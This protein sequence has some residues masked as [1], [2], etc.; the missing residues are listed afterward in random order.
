MSWYIDTLLEQ[1][2]D[3]QKKSCMPNEIRKYLITH[4]PQI[5]L[6]SSSLKTEEPRS[7]QLEKHI[8]LKNEHIQ[9]NH[10]N[11]WH[12][13]IID[14]DVN[15]PDAYLD[16]PVPVPN[17]IVFNPDS[18]HCQRW[19][20]LKNGV[21]RTYWAKRSIQDYYLNTLFKLTALYN[22]DAF[23]N[24]MLARN[25]FHHKHI[26]LYPRLETYTLKE[27]NNDM[28]ISQ[29]DYEKGNLY[30]SDAYLLIQ[31]Y[32]RKNRKLSENMGLG[33]NCT[34]FD[35]LRFKAY[36]IQYEYGTEADFAIDLKFEA[37]KINQDYFSQDQLSD[38]ELKHIANSIARYC[39]KRGHSSQSGK[40]FSERQKV[41]GTKGGESRSGNYAIA[42]KKC[43]DLYTQEPSLKVS[44]IA[45]EC[46]VSERTIRNY[47]KEIKKKKEPLVDFIY[48]STET[49]KELA[50]KFGVSVRTIQ[51]RRATAQMKA[52]K[53]IENAFS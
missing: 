7:Y 17:M 36:K 26:C 8:A 20:F 4:L 40:S 49:N 34:I 19:Y 30:K 11:I 5:M 42:R 38:N 23:Y 27:L 44:E 14:D 53:A 52:N 3:H 18:G 35:I 1:K 9:A 47:I 51:R 48:S 24:G 43:F 46:R 45:Q 16:L 39:F 13:I 29:S 2:K 33:R 37:Q 31:D 41:R 10:K 25:P 12:F 50:T 32:C 28:G 15:S 22:G 6:C 21:S